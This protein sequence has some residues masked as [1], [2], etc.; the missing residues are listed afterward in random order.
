MR[1]VLPRLS[2]AQAAAAWPGIEPVLEATY[3][4]RRCGPSTHTPE[5]VR[6]RVLVE[7]FELR[8]VVIDGEPS[9]WLIGRVHRGDEGDTYF[10]WWVTVQPGGRERARS[11]AIAIHR[12]ASKLGCGIVE[13]EGRPGWRRLLRQLGVEP[14]YCRFGWYAE[15]Q[16]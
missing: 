14:S 5:W 6:Q 1:V 11:V 9:G 10:V 7:H 15:V 8:Q 4:R 12:L 16:A 13:G 2:A 3:I